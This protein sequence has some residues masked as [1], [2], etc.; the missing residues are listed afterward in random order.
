MTE[1]SQKFRSISIWT[2]IVIFVIRC[3]FGWSDVSSAINEKKLLECGYSVFG[4]AGEAVGLAALFMFA[5]N[6]WLWR[7]KPLNMLAGGMP[8]L[9]K[10]YKGKIRYHWENR[11]S[12]RNFEI[13]V[14]Q[15]FLNV[16]I[17]LGT[18]ESSSNS[19]LATI[20]EE[21]GSKMLIYTYLN[22]P[23]AELQDRSSIHYGTV[24]LNVDDPSHLFGN[25]F[26]S[27][28][29]RGSMSFDAVRQ[30]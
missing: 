23:R 24:M 11:I 3:W 4:Y 17:R 29:S 22:T 21:N 8:I 25:Y 2:A 26:T 27:R 18:N 1:A 19:V 14:E 10:K 16:T 13:N 7:F 12:N 30:Q 9:A 5:F 15:T 20:K 6:K 28:L